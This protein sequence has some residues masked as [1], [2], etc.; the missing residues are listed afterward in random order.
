M[1]RHTSMQAQR[2]YSL[3]FMKPTFIGLSTIWFINFHSPTYLPKDGRLGLPDVKDRV[4]VSEHV[5]PP[6]V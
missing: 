2:D 3:S 6:G 5:A 1:S 4:A